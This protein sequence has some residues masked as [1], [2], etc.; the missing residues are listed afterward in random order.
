MSDYW[1]RNAC[2]NRAQKETVRRRC[3][4]CNLCGD[5]LEDD[6]VEYDHI[7]PYRISGNNKIG[8]YQS[9][10]HDC[11]TKKTKEDKKL[12]NEVKRKQKVCRI[13]QFKNG[14]QIAII[15]CDKGDTG[16]EIRINV[17]DDDDSF[18]K[19]YD[20]IMNEYDNYRI[21]CIRTGMLI[22]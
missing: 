13:Y 14:N 18:S 3:R 11:H 8:N 17:H 7:I 1:R 21:Y 15:L 5:P 2:L 16:E 22:S 4:G 9:L 6:D 10:C 20:E 12:I 19:Y